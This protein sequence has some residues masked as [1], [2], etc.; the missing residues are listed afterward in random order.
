MLSLSLSR[1]FKTSIIA[2]T[3]CV[4]AWTV[5]A[6][7]S[8]GSSDSSNPS[9]SSNSDLLMSSATLPQAP[10]SASQSSSAALASKSASI[11]GTSAASL[12]ACEQ[13][14]KV[15]K[16]DAE[17][18]SKTVDNLISKNLYSAEL[19]KN[20]WPEALAKNKSR[21]LES[22]NLSQLSERI[23]ESIKALKSSHTQFV[24]QNDEIFYFLHSLFGVSNKKLPNPKIDFTG[25]TTGGVD[26][27]FN[28]VRYVLESSPAAVAGIQR[29]DLIETVDGEKYLGQMSFAKRSNHPIKIALQRGDKKLT[30]M[31]TPK[32][33]DDYEQYVKAIEKSTKILP[34]CVGRLGY[35]RYWSGGR[36]AH[37]AFDRALLSDAMVNTEGVIIDLRDG[38]GGNSPDDLDMIY[39]PAAAYPKLHSTERSGKKTVDQEYYDKPVVVLINRGSRSG[40]EL[41]AYGLKKS[42]RAK[43]VGE[44]TAG[45]V[46][47]GRLYPI[48]DR[49]AL[50]L[51]VVDI[52]VNEDR[53]GGHGVAA[54]ISI[55]DDAEHPNGFTDQ[56]DAAR[57]TLIDLVK[58]SKPATSDAGQTD[59]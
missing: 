27:A 31:L 6:V 59:P 54:D 56:F 25:I 14:F 24:T 39:R 43:L 4:S 44:T 30:V 9:A 47:A 48:D 13:T 55:P 21:I 45:Y 33:E 23:N 53:L 32:L 20:V 52:S 41:L 46:L 11:S 50:Y 34:S 38:Y 15:T 18:Y 29:N 8:S 49:T 35:V 1:M 7:A 36:L 5:A 37:E 12:A 3:V 10:P 40:K 58:K 51:A 42:G 17:K 57:A 19:A 2:A 22:T 26:K 16:N 28:C